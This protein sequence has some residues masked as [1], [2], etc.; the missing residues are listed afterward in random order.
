MTPREVRFAKKLVESGLVTSEEAAEL[1]RLQEN[2]R[3][4][5]GEAGTLWSLAVERELITSA[6]SERLLKRLER[7]SAAL[8]AASAGGSQKLG[9]YELISKL[10][11][12]GMGAVY[13]ARQEN[14]DRTVALKVLPK[15]LAKDDEFI[16]RF[17]REAR[18]AG[19]LSHPNVVAGI[20]AGFADGYYYFAMEYVEG[21]N[22]G[23]R[24]DEEKLLPESEAAEFGRQVALALEHAH[25]EGIV[26]RDVKPENIIITPSGQTK[27]CDLGLARGTEED[28]RLTQAGM[29]VGTPYY[30]SPEQ[31]R[32]RDPDGRADIYSLG[33]T[34]YHLVTG[35]PP[36][37]G[38]NSM[39]I[40]QKHM[41][42]PPPPVS[43]VVPGISKAMERVIAK[44]MAR[45]KE[46]RYATAAEAADDLEK[47]L[48]G[49]VPSAL[50]AAV[51]ARRSSVRRR[52]GT[53][54]SK[55]STGPLAATAGEE[56]SPSARQR[57]AAQ[58]SLP[59]GLI[60][61]GAVLFVLAVVTGWSMM[62]ARTSTPDEIVLPPP[63]GGGD[64]PVEPGGNSDLPVVPP[65]SGRE[66]TFTLQEDQP[67]PG[68]GVAA[69]AG[70]R[71][72][73]VGSSGRAREK[74]WDG[75]GKTKCGRYDRQR[76]LV[77][78]A[79][80]RNEGGPLP[81]DAEILEAKLRL[82]KV[83]PYAPR[84]SLHR[85][86][87]DWSEAEV[88]WESIVASGGM[89]EDY[90]G[91]EPVAVNDLEKFYRA[92]LKRD[93]AKAD[94]LWKANI[95]WWCEFDVTDDLRRTVAEGRNFGWVLIAP[96]KEAGKPMINEIV[97]AGRFNKERAHRPQ[98]IIKA[99]CRDK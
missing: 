3:A 43:E 91:R 77:R 18:A 25:D 79:V 11:Q 52:P 60:V 30:I 54:R 88:T 40:M 24:L 17:L 83:G 68:A 99:R 8:T 41:G 73:Q 55:R 26:H 82:C 19:R 84:L 37:D 33:C 86:H 53:T 7:E 38:P 96:G 62:T 89:E 13:K 56:A 81:D 72:G 44:M 1:A 98:L 57:R 97:F 29:A 15:S 69:Y 51:A 9:G 71:T 90:A 12:G 94:D 32:G 59:W 70:T 46:D 39:A 47:V 31:V 28:L 27:L 87:A 4:E 36:F 42:D 6:Q 2:R 21:V 50:S 74:H 67:V 75:R 78:F 35:R 14:M 93:R 85:L 48:A 61:A 49:G 20:D 95:V 23:Q 63:P 65:G 58:K 66:Q 80:T 16:S 5:S 92:L 10:G 64:D 45:E 22:L 76:I 34:L